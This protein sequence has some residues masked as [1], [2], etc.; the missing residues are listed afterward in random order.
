M[1]RL[2][3]VG[4]AIH[5]Q[6]QIAVG[7][8]DAVVDEFALRVDLVILGEI[9]DQRAAK[10][11]DVPRSCVVLLVGQA[12]RVGE[13]RILHAQFGCVLV[14]QLGKGGFTARNVF[15]DGNACVVAGL[16]DDAVHQ[17]IQ[18][19]LGPHV[20]KHARFA[21]INALFPGLFADQDLVVPIQAAILDLVVDHIA[22]QHLGD[23]GGLDPRV[24]IA[25]CQDLATGVVHQH[26]GSRLD[27]GRIRNLCGYCAVAGEE[28]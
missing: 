9:V 5:L 14:H 11:R 2:D 27:C 13:V 8:F 26:E 22:Q 23:A 1:T 3:A 21:R 20:E 6:Q 24:G 25:F 15:S 10:N 19:H 17:I 16:N 28:N 12:G 7:L 4:I 18:F